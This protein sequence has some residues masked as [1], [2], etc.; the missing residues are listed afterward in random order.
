MQ[1][2]LKRLLNSFGKN[3][4]ELSKVQSELGLSETVENL[5]RLFPDVHGR[6]KEVCDSQPVTL[7]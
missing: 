2:R 6:M 1:A 5:K 3:T 7:L 4:D